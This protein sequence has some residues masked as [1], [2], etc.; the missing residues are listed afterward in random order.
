MA[1]SSFAFV[2][3]TR[4]HEDVVATEFLGDMDLAVVVRA[5][6]HSFSASWLSG[7]AQ[8]VKA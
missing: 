4:P 1:A 3:M 2:S 8:L 5:A 7:M 6:R